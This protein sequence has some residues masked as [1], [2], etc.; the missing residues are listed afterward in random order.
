MAKASII[1]HNLSML[2]LAISE[3]GKAKRCKKGGKRWREHLIKSS[4]WTGKIIKIKEG[5]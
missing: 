5:K 3:I 1:S 2:K 4:Y